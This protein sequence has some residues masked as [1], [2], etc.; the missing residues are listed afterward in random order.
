MKSV[1]YLEAAH[2]QQS[3]LSFNRK[4]IEIGIRKLL[5]ELG[6]DWQIK[7]KHREQYVMLMSCRAMN[8]HR[9]V[10]Q[11]CRMALSGQNH[12]N[13]DAWVWQL[14]WMA[15]K[16]PAAAE[17]PAERDEAPVAAKTYSYGFDRELK[18][19]WR[20]KKGQRP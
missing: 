16:R 15:D 9:M 1:N 11:N 20:K 10:D 6:D 3:N 12:M 18:L 5:E 13:Q 17:E 8:M 19:G 2:E 7:E 4:S 14:P